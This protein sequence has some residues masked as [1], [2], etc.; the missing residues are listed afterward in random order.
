MTLKTLF[1]KGRRT[2]IQKALE[3]GEPLP[4][5][6]MKN[7]GLSEPARNE[8]AAACEI[9]AFIR[10]IRESGDATK[11]RLDRATEYNEKKMGEI[12]AEHGSEEIEHLEVAVGYKFFDAKHG[13]SVT[14]TPAEE[15]M[16][17]QL[18]LY[19]LIFQLLE[20]VQA[21]DAIRATL[22]TKGKVGP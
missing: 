4:F 7:P 5:Q 19:A 8:N 14:Y 22:G 2:D 15:M 17:A 20:R 21:E 12:A 18:E 10:S 1:D 6:R 3:K 9:R 13:I 11:D 16:L